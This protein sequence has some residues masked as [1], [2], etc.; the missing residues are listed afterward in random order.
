MVMALFTKTIN[1]FQTAAT[2]SLIGEE[3]EGVGRRKKLLLPLYS[4]QSAVNHTHC[5]GSNPFLLVTTR[6]TFDSTQ[7]GIPGLLVRGFLILLAKQKW[8]SPK[9]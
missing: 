3:E 5:H 4:S 9:H 1:H 8:N 7:N 2:S 6:Q